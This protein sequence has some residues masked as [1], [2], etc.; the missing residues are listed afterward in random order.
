MIGKE[1]SL[2][3]SSRRLTPPIPTSASKS[4]EEFFMLGNSNTLLHQEFNPDTDPK[5]RRLWNLFEK[6]QTEFNVLIDTYKATTAARFLR[7]TIENVISYI[8]SNRTLTTDSKATSHND[9]NG[10]QKKIFELEVVLKQA[11]AVAERGCGGNKRRFDFTRS[12]TDV[13]TDSKAIK[14][15]RSFEKSL[16]GVINPA[17]TSEPSHFHQRGNTHRGRDR[18]PFRQERSRSPHREGF[19]PPRYP[20]HWV[21]SYRPTY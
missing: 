7:D 15:E 9:L 3:F 5:F 21:D 6:A 8:E 16:G 13:P 1:E 2:F 19:L 20:R 14:T 18:L 17:D 11:M 10:L 12:I 4:D